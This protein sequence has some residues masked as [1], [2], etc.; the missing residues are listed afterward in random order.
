MAKS[1]KKQWI[2]WGGIVALFIILFTTDL[3]TEL[4]SIMKRGILK[5]GFLNASFE[6]NVAPALV[7]DD[8]FTLI[9]AKNETIRFQSLAQKPTLIK[10]WATWCPSCTAELPEIEKLYQE[11]GDKVNVVLISVDEN[12]N[13]LSNF[14][15]KKGYDIPV[16]QLGSSYPEAFRARSIP[17]SYILDSKRSL[18]YEREGMVNFNIESF[19]TFLT[20]ID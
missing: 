20:T 5:T 6:K 10:F 9:N 19:K 15:E 8:D 13:K 16:Y 18:V 2:E 1:S 14:L 7:V 11:T 4:S 3:G 12:R 17:R